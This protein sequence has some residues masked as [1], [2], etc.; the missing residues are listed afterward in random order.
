MATIADC[1]KAIEGLSGPNGAEQTQQ[2]LQLTEAAIQQNPRT[3]D[4]LSPPK[5]V[6]PKPWV[7]QNN[8]N[9]DRRQTRSMTHKRTVF[10]GC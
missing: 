3:A 5:L 8:V 6:Q 10:R 7:R 9:D 1:A 2:L 4:G